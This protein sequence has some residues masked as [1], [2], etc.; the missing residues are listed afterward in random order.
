VATLIDAAD[1]G[2]SAKS[3]ALAAYAAL[4]E[5]EA[6]AHGVTT[7]EVH[8]HEVGSPRAIYTVTGVAI[9]AELLGVTDFSC[10]ELRDGS[11]VIECSHGTIPV[12]VPAVRELLKRTDLPL[13]S[14]PDIGTEL[15]TPT[16]LALLIGLGCRYVRD[17]GAPGQVRSVGYG[18][19]TRDSGLLGAVRA[20][21]TRI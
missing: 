14:D 1:I 3:Y 2:S 6:A 17:G 4:A 10:G 7:N 9:A 20:T 5:A 8:F 21:L 16:G 19:G 13:V 15:V 11:G 18:F 12:P